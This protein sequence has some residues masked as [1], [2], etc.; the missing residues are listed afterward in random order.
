MSAEQ[1]ITRE[2]ALPRSVATRRAGGVLAFPV[3]DREP[4]PLGRLLARVPGEGHPVWTY[5]IGVLLSFAAIACLSI[6][7]G[8]LVTHVLLHVHGVASDDEW[9]ARFLRPAP[10][11]RD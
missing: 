6:L 2:V 1:S 10:L 3:L 4:G 7:A 11:A 8:L 5:V 9:L